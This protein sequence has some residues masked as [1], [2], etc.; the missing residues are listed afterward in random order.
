MSGEDVSRAPKNGVVVR[1]GSR[2]PSMECLLGVSLAGGGL[3]VFLGVEDMTVVSDET[4]VH[5]FKW[6]SIISV[7]GKYISYH[8]CIF[9]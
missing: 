3:G 4:L 2:A 5:D 6:N 7:K 1:A 8:C 9:I